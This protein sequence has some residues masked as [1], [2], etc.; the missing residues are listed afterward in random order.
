[1]L[2]SVLRASLV[3]DILRR[4]MDICQKC[5][6]GCTI[7]S[8]LPSALWIMTAV[9]VARRDHLEDSH[10]CALEQ[11]CLRV[12]WH[13][14]TCSNG[15]NMHLIMQR[16][17]G[18]G[19]GSGGEWYHQNHGDSDSLLVFLLETYWFTSM[20]GSSGVHGVPTNL[21]QN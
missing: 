9:Y 15:R 13:S 2:G 10:M 19:E 21:P 17:G 11:Y 20:D 5:L 3:V 4:Y 7:L 18:L 12:F 16:D 14:T 1:M 8:P 6:Y